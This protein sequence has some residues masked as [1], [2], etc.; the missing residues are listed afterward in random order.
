MADPYIDFITTSH[1]LYD[2]YRKTW[3]KSRDS[4]YGAEEYRQ[5]RYLK[6][7][8]SDLSMPADTITTYN[9]NED[10]SVVGKYK[11]SVTYGQGKYETER[12]QESVT[13][14]FYDEKLHSTPFLNFVKLIV[15]E[16]SSIL[17]RN[18]PQRVLG[19]S[20][21]VAEFVQNV[22]G[23][24]ENLNEFMALLDQLTTVYGV[25]HVMCYKP[26]GSDIPR[27]K[28]YTPLDVT[29]WEYSYDID[30][31]LKLKK[32][33]IRIEDSDEHTIYRLIT[34]ETIETIFV[35]EDEDYVPN[36]DDARLEKLKKGM[37]RIVQ[38]NEL[39]YIFLKT[40]YQGAKIYNN[41]GATVIQDVADINQAITNYGAEIYASV[42]YS[43]HP[44][45][46]ADDTTI[47][48]NGG[49]LAS[50][51]GSVVS[52]QAS[53]TGTPSYVY[54]FVSPNLESIDKIQAI[55]DSYID[56]LSQ[57]A[58]LRTED[59]IKSAKS[60]EQIQVYDDKLAAQIR[61][62]ATNMENIEQKL[63]KMFFDWTNIT[64][65]ED[66]SVSY[67]RQYNKKAIEQ[68]VA[69]INQLMNTYKMYKDMFYGGKTEYE[70]EEYATQAEAEQ[71]AREL[72]GSGFHSHTEEDGTTVYMPFATHEQ[73]EAAM[74]L[75][76]PD[77]DY[78]E[79][80]DFDNEMRD[81]IRMRLE[82]LV[83]STTTNNG[84]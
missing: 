33:V 3:Q 71:R 53:L 52:V 25:C 47:D 28:I 78:I 2:R 81:K 61:R 36:V 64:M 70:V 8:A 69:E 6:A 22:D 13:G 16:Y 58:M 44:T 83:S 29:N 17:F 19:D 62:K 23:T 59:L 56:K 67:N 34:P 24:G 39:G 9:V 41:V 32:V 14:T 10:G 55:I 38:P 35:S 65:P 30:G 18:P 42:A 46:V 49:H 72:G 74:E 11:A 31:N 57:I 12:G 80:E 66:F 27:W 15:S 68:E 37:Y 79:T 63:W 48:R 73:Y 45:L 75:N 76:N 1:S 54:E 5:G 82:Q 7:Y 51:P 43:A 40:C 77:V 60:G 26:I 50:E 20:P 84:L 21:E 4:W